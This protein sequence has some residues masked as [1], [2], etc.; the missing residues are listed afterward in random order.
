MSGHLL[1]WKGYGMESLKQ[2]VDI[3][4]DI[5]VRMHAIC[6]NVIHSRWAAFEQN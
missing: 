4:K 1:Q 3:N 6:V 2:L 5:D